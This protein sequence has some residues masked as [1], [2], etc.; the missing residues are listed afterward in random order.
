MDGSHKAVILRDWDVDSACPIS[1]L[2]DRG[3]TGLS[4]LSA[5]VD[6]G[7]VLVLPSFGTFHDGWNCVRGSSKE[8]GGSTWRAVIRTA[9]IGNLPCEHCRTGAWGKLLI[10]VHCG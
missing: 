6:A 3:S 7:T 8:D 4:G 2:V 9:S 1:H 5:I 10:E